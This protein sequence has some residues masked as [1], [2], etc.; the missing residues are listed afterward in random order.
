MRNPVERDGLGYRWDA[1]KHGVVLKA[2]RLHESGESLS[3]EVVIERAPEG[4]LL[5]T[6]INLLAAQTRAS[7]AKQLGQTRGGQDVPWAEVLERFT[8]GVLELER[9]GPPFERIGRRPLRPQPP[10]LLRPMLYV[11]KPTILFGQGGVG[12]SSAIAAAIVVSVRTGVAALDAWEV[13]DSGEVLVLDWEGDA[14]DWND[15][16]A[17]VA[18]GLQIEAPE[19]HYRRMRGPLDAQ[20]NE[21]A[22]FCDENDIKLLVIDSVTW[23]QRTTDRGS[24]EE[25]T[26]RLF[27][28]LRSIGRSSLLIDHMSKASISD[29]STTG[30]NPIGSIVKVNA[31]RAVFEVRKADD[32]DPDGTRHLALINHKQNP[33]AIQPPLGVAVRIVG[34]ETRVWTE[35]VRLNDAA[36]AREAASSGVLWE[37]IQELLRV[38]GALTGP[39][40]VGFLGI[41][42]R[43]PL[44]TVENAMTRKSTIFGVAGELRQTRKWYLLEAREHARSN[45]PSTREHDREHAP[46]MLAEHG[47]GGYIKGGEESLGNTS[48]SP[49]QGNARSVDSSPSRARTAGNVGERMAAIF[50]SAPATEEPDWL[51]GLE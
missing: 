8:E 5:R 44:R 3:A 50:A 39:S 28:A 49:S 46:S 45:A 30:A 7:L 24:S 2:D 17:R 20:V 27:D 23:A 14:D 13:V 36:V 29:D 1:T 35:A 32:Q 51:E 11:G 18:A 9:E 38:R 15:A 4:R 43:D 40:I 6:R 16:V 33:T 37:R 31:A 12:K 48:I 22:A 34:G 19:F 41:D 26:K 25:P 42:G 21:I 10:S 47:E